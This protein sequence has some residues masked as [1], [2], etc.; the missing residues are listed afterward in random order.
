[1]VIPTLYARMD[2]EIL[3]HGSRASSVLKAAQARSMVNLVV[4]L[5]D[6]LV[7][8]DNIFDHT[9]D[10]RTV[11]VAGRAHLIDDP[12]A[13]ARAAEH[14]SR[15]VRPGRYETVRAPDA[16]ELRQ[17]SLNAVSI[18][19]AVMKFSDTGLEELDSSDTWTGK[20]A[21]GLRPVSPLP[22]NSWNKDRT[23][24]DAEQVASRFLR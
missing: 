7:L 23:G 21:L 18:E 14:L 6:A 2:D 19:Q 22:S 15:A 5:V 16:K 8:P 9:I 10:Y 11:S 13:K 1:M 24:T 4:I 17:T 20:Q 12:V 3:V